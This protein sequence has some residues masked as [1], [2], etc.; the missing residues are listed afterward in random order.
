VKWHITTSDKVHSAPAIAG[1][2]LYIASL[3]RNIYALNAQNGR[4]LHRYRT[5]GPISAAPV[6]AGNYLYIGDLSGYV[7]AF[8]KAHR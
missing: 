6:L 1:G 7:Y 4:E 5:E 3:D 2:V 8:H